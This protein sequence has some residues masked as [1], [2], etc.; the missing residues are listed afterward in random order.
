MKNNLFTIFFILFFNC[1]VIFNAK[2]IEQ[3]NFD[4]TELVITEDGNNFK[5]LKRG[6]ATTSDGIIIHADAFNYNKSSNILKANGNVIIKDTIK[7]IIIYSED[8][9]YLKNEEKIFTRSRVIEDDYNVLYPTRSKVINN[10]LIM[11]ADTLEYNKILNIFNADGDVKIE[12]KKKNIIIYSD[13]VTYFKNK[14]KILTQGR[15][16]AIIESKYNFISK[17]V[18]YLLN[19]KELS[20]SDKSTIKSGESTIYKLDRFKYF[21]NDKLLKGE[22][23]E[24]TTN[25]LQPKSDKFY[26]KDGF[27]NFQ[28]SKFIANKTKILLHKEIFDK[29]RKFFI[30]QE[31]SKLNELFEEYYQE[32]DPR[33]IGVSSYGDQDKTV[34]NKGVFTSCQ[35]REGCPPWILTANKITHDKKKQLLI[36]DNAILKVFDMPVFYFPKFFHP[37]PTVKRKSGFLKPQINGS[38]ILGTSLYM[39]YF[40]VISDDKDLTFKPTVFIDG[41]ESGLLMLQSEYRQENKNSS[42]IADFSLTRGYQSSNIGSNKNS[43]SHLF[44]KFDLDL[45]WTDYKKSDINVFLEKVTN[46]SYL[47]IFDNNLVK[48]PVK[49]LSKSQLS[50]GVKLNLDHEDFNLTSGFTAYESL[51]GL[52]SDR[53]QYVLPYYNFSRNVLPSIK[54]NF[55][56]SSS[57]SNTLQNT[58]NLR[59]RVGNDLSYDSLDFVSN[60]GFKNDFGIYL[61]NLNSVGKNDSVSS[62][63]PLIEGMSIFE[64][65]SSLPLIKEAKNYVSYLTPRLSLRASPHDM[66]DYSE[67]ART[68]NVDNVFNINRLGIG[69]SFETG[70]SLTLGVDYIKQ[71]IADNEKFFEIK[72]ATVMRNEKESNIPT[73]ST[74]DK[75]SSNLFGS[76]THE[77]SEFFKIDYDFAM[78]NDFQT[79]E[80]NIIT[81]EYSVNNFVTEFVYNENRLGN[82]NTLQNTTS[83]RFSEQNYFTFSTRRNKELNL[84]EYY[85]LVYEYK[86][87]CL[88]AGVKYKKTYYANEDIRPNEDLMFTVTLFPLTIFE[89]RV[90]QDVYRGKDKKVN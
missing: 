73:T 31:D 67:S 37:D 29:E 43:I 76:I 58:N 71:D 59:T 13:N 35:K 65:R 85:D 87:D 12:D 42:F 70:K 79:F 53:F 8:I 38:K 54:G 86:N 7:D 89:Q 50:S 57:G 27:F 28:D 84:T 30:D 34:V 61:K 63:R 46:D 41:F 32:N 24:V 45:D 44:S 25:F 4:V 23:I 78:N 10:G 68:V 1:L 40:H 80:N 72:L 3:F 60:F 22:N 20:S 74:I 81:A 39:P 16:K 48:S 14:Q 51:A 56:F 90:N 64:I 15:T 9:T 75:T 83:L 47:S 11:D 19:E 77:I 69:D 52:N 17:N 62:S 6:V 2:S 88:T 33:V 21:I 5:G 55:Y 18:L 36:Y 82:T 49:P 66:K 26:F